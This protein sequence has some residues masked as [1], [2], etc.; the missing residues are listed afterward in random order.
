MSG[1]GGILDPYSPQALQARQ[2]QQFGP[3]SRID[4]SVYPDLSI[5]D[6]P[7]SSR[8]SP[9]DLIVFN[10]IAMPLVKLKSG[11]R[12]EIDKHKG[13]G[14]DWQT[15]ISKGYMAVE[16]HITI[17]LF[18]DTISGMDWMSR[19]DIQV[20]D[21]LMPRRIDLRDAIKVFNPLLSGDGISQILMESRGLPEHVGKQI[22]HVDL[23]G[24]DIRFASQQKNG[25]VVKK[26]RPAP[27]LRAQPNALRNA[28]EAGNNSA[29]PSLG[30]AGGEP[31]GPNQNFTPGAG[32]SLQSASPSAGSVI[33]PAMSLAGAV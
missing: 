13:R 31:T 7:G 24:W 29:A 8:I 11:T 21:M 1:N 23:V 19:Y 6:G 2:N 28:V 3:S 4:E 9:Y 32:Q 16:T 30:L 18:V 25:N 17:A 12:L 14:H 33:T 20:R 10:G 26:T 5:W 15:L 22:F 27:G